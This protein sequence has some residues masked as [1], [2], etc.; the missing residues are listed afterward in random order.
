MLEKN[1]EDGEWDV[2]CDFCSTSEIFPTALYMFEDMLSELKKDGWLFKKRNEEWLHAC[3]ECI[4][5][6]GKK[7]FNTAI[8]DE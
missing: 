1:K 5:E 8:L 2:S 6:H 4:E 7:I 3:P